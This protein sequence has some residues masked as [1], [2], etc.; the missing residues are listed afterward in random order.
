MKTNNRLKQLSKLSFSNE[1]KTLLIVIDGLGG[2]P[3]PGFDNKSELEYADLKNHNSK[4]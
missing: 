3:H 4:L 1:K 2:L